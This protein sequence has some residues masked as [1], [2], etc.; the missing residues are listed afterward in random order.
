MINLE[1]SILKKKIMKK[2][3]IEEYLNSEC[4]TK[5]AKELVACE[6]NVSVSDLEKVFFET[7]VGTIPIF[8]NDVCIGIV[9][10]K[11][12]WLWRFN[13]KKEPVLSDVLSPRSDIE[14]VEVDTPLEKTIKIVKDKSVV[15]FIVNN[16]MKLLSSKCLTDALNDLTQVFIPLYKLESRLKQHLIDHNFDLHEIDNLLNY[17]SRFTFHNNLEE[18]YKKMSLSHLRIIYV[19]KWKIIKKN[20]L[21][22]KEIF[23]KEMHVL[24]RVRNEV[25]HFENFHN[26]QNVSLLINKVLSYFF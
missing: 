25:M 17:K 16:E 15:L 26:T 23:V 20:K 9:K 3:K 1:N 14:T 21:A 18:I 8:E 13:N 2:I 4:L 22:E 24:N 7:N 12:L 5:Y 6:S 10:R 11:N 19:E